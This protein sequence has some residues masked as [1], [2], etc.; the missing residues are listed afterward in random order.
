MSGEDSSPDREKGEIHKMKKGKKIVI[1]VGVLLAVA[2][3]SGLTTMAVTNYGSPDDPLVTLSYLNETVTPGILQQLNAA[4]EA[5]ISALQAQL[6]QITAQGG[7]GGETPSSAPSGFV[8]LTLSKG[9]TVTCGV[10]T[11]IMPRIGT[12]LSFGPD[13]PRLVDE[14]DAVSVAESGAALTTNHM[15]MVTING[16][17]VKADRDNTKILIRGEYTVN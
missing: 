7:G 1:A 6:D 14:T 11:E 9:Q 12:V 3:V 17:G 10:G 4:L 8:V 15:Y 5:R 2:L 16:N 13:N